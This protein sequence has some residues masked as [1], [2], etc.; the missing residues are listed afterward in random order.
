M[1][2]MTKHTATA[3][4]NHHPGRIFEALL[5]AE[6]LPTWNPAF[7]HV[8]P[9]GPNGSHPV[10]VQKLLKGTLTY[11]QP[12]HHCLELDITIPGLVEHSI[13]TLKPQGGST[14]VTH[15]VTQRGFLCT[16]IGDHEASLVPGK[17]P[18]RLARILDNK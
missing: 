4:L 18:N 10:T 7:T 12:N 13:F 3:I 2:Y 1:S 16:V 11:A 17:R 8:G 5:D 6:E 9:A 14:R 15:T